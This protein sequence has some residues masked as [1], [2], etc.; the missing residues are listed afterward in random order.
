MSSIFPSDLAP[1]GHRLPA[2]LAVAAAIAAGA[3]A[4]TAVQAQAA[5]AGDA[6]P[7]VMAKVKDR[8]LVVRGTPRDDTIALRLAPGRPDTL[9]VDAGGGVAATI[10]RS[11]LDSILV[12]ARGGDDVVRIDESGG[13]FTD[14]TPTTIDGGR[15]DDQLLG[16]SGAERLIGGDG[17]DFV[18]GGRGSDVAL[19]GAG[20]DTFQW[21]PGEGSDTVEGQDGNDTMVFNGANVA[22]RFEVSA[23]GGRVRFTR[24]IGTITMD[25]AGVERIETNAL[26]GAD[27]FTQHDVTGTDLVADHVD[28]A[29]PGGAAGDGQPDRIVVEGTAGNDA[30][31]VAGDASGVAV[32]G[33]AAR[34]TVAHP[35]AANDALTVDALAGDDVVDASG[36]AQGALSYAARGGEGNDLLLGSAGDDTLDGGPGDDVLNGGPGLDVL[37]G[38]PGANVVIQG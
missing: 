31:S 34:V 4:A 13:V 16:G 32:N 14:T 5:P 29:G 21:D 27:T 25:L 9:E 23:S 18:D 30:I 35:E 26:G 6:G 11:Q 28:L 1:G 15:G 2:R 38:G 37:D 8:T 10:R 17:A 24:D 19:L 33:L 7:P 3:L 12:K 20:D 36:L 22:E